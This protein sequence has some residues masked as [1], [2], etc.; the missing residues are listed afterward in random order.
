M[1]SNSSTPAPPVRLGRI[2]F[3][4][5]VLVIIGLAIGL[6]PRLRASRALAQEQAASDIPTVSVISA[7]ASKPDFST[8]LPAE[9]ESFIQASIHAQASGYLKK[10][11]VDIGD[12]VTNGQLLAEIETPELDQQILQAQADLDQAKAALSLSQI[13]ADR[14]VELLK[15]ASVSDQETAEK[16]SDLALKKAALEAADANLQRLRQLKIFDSVTAPFDGTITLR[17]TDIGQ[18]ISA[19]SGPELFRIAQVNPLRVYV[20]VPQPLIHAIMPGQTAELSFME[21]PGRVFDAKVT[22]TAGAVDPTSRTLQVQL[23]ADNSHGEILSGSYAQVRFSEIPSTVP[24]LQISDNAL[25]FRAQGMQLAVVGSDNHVQLRS[26]RL[27]R[28]FGN[29]V[30][31]LSG[32]SADDRIVDNPPDSLADGDQVEIAQPVD[33]NVAAK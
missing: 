4:I 24:I 29:T 3:I 31:V 26:V 7:T 28:D 8:P 13:T 2:A 27:G 17:N 22:R 10:W 23:E 30:E 1:N 11:Y 18:L 21:L 32:I 14:W 16:T 9:V 12:K 15:T 20:Q 33:T 19:N 6:V 5:V 25:I